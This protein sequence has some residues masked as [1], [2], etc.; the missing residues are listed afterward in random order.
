MPCIWDIERKRMASAIEG[1]T[2]IR[3]ISGSV[4]KGRKKYLKSQVLTLI[5]FV[6]MLLRYV[7]NP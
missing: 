1:Y 5:T 6:L 4:S 3:I 2:L 7:E